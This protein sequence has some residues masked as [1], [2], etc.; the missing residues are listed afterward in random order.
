MQFQTK[1]LQ[2]PN[3]IY[4]FRHGQSVGNARGMDD[5][6]L[7]DVANHEFELTEKG[8]EQAYQLG[9]HLSSSGILREID[10]S[11]VSSFR[12]S[13]QTLE[14]ALENK[15]FQ[16]PVY[17]DDRMDEW[18]KGIFHS[19]SAQERDSAYPQ[20]QR[21][22]EREGLHHYRPPQGEAGK[23]VESRVK[24]FLSELEGTPLLSGHGRIAGFMDRVIRQLPYNKNCK[25]AKPSNGELWRFSKKNGAYERET[26][27]KP[28]I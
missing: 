10:E 28:T 8:I 26:L 25:Y 15:Q 13:Q 19:M 6:S 5:N 12:R 9:A 18:W 11:Y 3:K 24:A 14:V 23:D 21:I 20:E 2:L 7:T 1:Q 4:L 27:F 16:F 22:M 17:H